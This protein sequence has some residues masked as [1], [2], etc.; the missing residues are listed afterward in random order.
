[1][2]V[3]LL[4]DHKHQQLAYVLHHAMLHLS[5]HVLHIPGQLLLRLLVLLLLLLAGSV[6][7]R[8]LLLLLEVLLLLLLLCGGSGAAAVGATGG[9]RCCKCIFAHHTHERMDVYVQGMA[10]TQQQHSRRMYVSSGNDPFAAVV[11][12]SCMLWS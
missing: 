1:M 8:K 4:C 7:G 5:G 12:V 9:T 2:L 6:C 11:V 10:A 3:G